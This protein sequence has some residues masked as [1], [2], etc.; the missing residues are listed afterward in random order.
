VAGVAHG[1]PPCRIDTAGVILRVKDLFRGHKE[2]VLGFNTFLPKVL[3]G[4]RM[5]PA[6]LPSVATPAGQPWACTSCPPPSLDTQGYEIQLADV[7]DMDDVSGGLLTFAPASRG[8]Q[9]TARRLG[10]HQWGGS[11]APIVRR[12]ERSIAAPGS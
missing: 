7:A 12:R 1:P 8:D 5:R 10:P 4:V 2:L 6:G 11:A 9:A 3:R